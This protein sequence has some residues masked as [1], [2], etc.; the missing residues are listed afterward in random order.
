MLRQRRQIAARFIPAP[1]GNARSGLVP[2]DWRAVHPRA[3][4]ERLRRAAWVFTADGSSPRLR[5]TLELHCLGCLTDRFIPAPAGNARTPLPR[6]SHRP[7]HPRACGERRLDTS[8]QI[9]HGGSSPRLR[10]T[11]AR[12]EARRRGRRFIPAPAGN[13]SCVRPGAWS[14]TGS[15]PRL[16][17]TR[18]LPHPPAQASRFIPTP[19]GNAWPRPEPRRHEPVHPRAC[20]ERAVVENPRRIATG[21]SPRLR[22]TPPMPGPCASIFSVHPR[23]CGERL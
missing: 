1:A 18:N 9:R 8:D 20:G 6:M 23:A 17:G 12:T 19:A 21:S 15:S 3:C 5:G 7:V 10:G 4:G 13:A 22:G 14:V 16:R 2:W 11:H